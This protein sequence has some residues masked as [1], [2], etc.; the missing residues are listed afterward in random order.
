MLIRAFQRI[1]G[2]DV[3]LVVAGSTSF[4]AHYVE[5]LHEL[6]AQ[7]SRVIMPGNVLREPLAD[8]YAHASAF[9]L[10]SDVEGMP[11][12]L[13]EAASHGAPILASDIAPHREF[14]GSDGPGRRLFRQG[15][16]DDLTRKLA[17]VL[18]DV[19]G[20]RLGAAEIRSHVAESYSWDQTAGALSD[21]YLSLVRDKRT[22]AP[23]G[24]VS[25]LPD[26]AVVSATPAQGLDRAV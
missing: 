20:E 1:E 4:T 17:M 11:L 2:D 5:Q 8:L 16:E 14:L 19:E 23:L 6:A 10:P 9:V 12:T 13:L 21:L 22:K 24:H 18:A 7:D 25:T 26:S 15:S 3:R